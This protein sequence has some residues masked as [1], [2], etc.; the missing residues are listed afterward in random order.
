MKVNKRLMALAMF[1]RKQIAE[2]TV[3]EFR[4]LMQECFDADRAEV[5]RRKQEKADFDHRMSLHYTY[6]TPA[7]NQLRG[8]SH[9]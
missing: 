6:G 3:A 2:L 8:F 5:E 4:G 7:P 9:E 1:E